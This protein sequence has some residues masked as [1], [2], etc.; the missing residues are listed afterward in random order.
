MDDLLGLMPERFRNK[1]EVDSETGC[2][3]WNGAATRAGYPLFTVRHGMQRMAYRWAYELLNGPVDRSLVM[4]HF[5]CD[6]KGC[7]NPEHV[8]P[9]TQRENI[10]RGTSP[11]C[12]LA[13]QTH[14]IH[15]H[16]FDRE[17]TY[18]DKKNQRHCRACHRRRMRERYHRLKAERSAGAA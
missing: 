10:L 4:D 17:N 9:V 14:C 7:A 1:V 18:Y 5:V 11:A 8:R 2:W 12:A 3:E 16:E 15:G 13:A 6:N